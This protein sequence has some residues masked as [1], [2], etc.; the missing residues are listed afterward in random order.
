MLDLAIQ[1]VHV[2]NQSLIFSRRPDARSRL[3]GGYRIFYSHGSALGSIAST[4]IFGAW[5]WSG[6]CMLGGGVAL[7]ALVFWVATLRLGH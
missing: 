1:A 3:V 2:T 7:A 5:G 6:V 4:M